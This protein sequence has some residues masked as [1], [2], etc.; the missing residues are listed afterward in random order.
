MKVI[1]MKVGMDC[2]IIHS[3]RR[4]RTQAACKMNRQTKRQ[5]NRHPDRKR[6]RHTDR[7]RYSATDDRKNDFLTLRAYTL[8]LSLHPSF[9]FPSLDEEYKV[10]GWEGLTWNPFN[11]A[12]QQS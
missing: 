10:H 6:H 2:Q 1:A 11:A 5:P 7:Q 12:T 4:T 8:P 3:N 9:P